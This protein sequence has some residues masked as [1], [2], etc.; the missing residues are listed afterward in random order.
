MEPTLQVLVVGP[1][2]PSPSLL[3]A[4]RK[5]GVDPRPC[6]PDDVLGLLSAAVA[7]AVVAQ[8]IPFWRL[9]LSRVVTAGRPRCCMFPRV[10]CRARSL[11]A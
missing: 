2:T 5:G 9:L 4:L 6:L 3:E 7:E 1:D 10:L 8:P 11:P